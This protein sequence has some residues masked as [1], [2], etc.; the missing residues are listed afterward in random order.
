MHTVDLPVPPLPEATTITLSIIILPLLYSITKFVKGQ[1][2][3]NI[4]ISKFFVNIL[5][6]VAKNIFIFLLLAQPL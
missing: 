2:K 5:C 1:Q 4:F 3:R 6:I